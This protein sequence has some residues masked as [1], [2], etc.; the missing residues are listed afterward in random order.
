MV[1]LADKTTLEWGADELDWVSE[2]KQSLE[3]AEEAGMQDWIQEE[4]PPG[5]HIRPASTAS[6]CEMR[7]PAG[8]QLSP[9]K[10]F[11]PHV[12]VGRL[13]LGSTSEKSNGSPRRATALV[14]A[15]PWSPPMTAHE[16]RC[17]KK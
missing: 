5:C 3:L 6:P 8:P 2:L 4:L 13:S 1:I 15:Q 16:I 14:A 10:V 9:R 17:C 11:V 7:T 12:A